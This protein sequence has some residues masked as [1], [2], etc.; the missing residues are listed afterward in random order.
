M[1][2]FRRCSVVEALSPPIGCAAALAGLLLLGCGPA[3]QPVD[4]PWSAQAAAI[5][6]FFSDDKPDCDEI[7]PMGNVEG[8]SKLSEKQKKDG[9]KATLDSA[10]SWLRHETAQRGANAVRVLSHSPSDDGGA[11]LITGEAFFCRRG[12]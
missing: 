7:L 8:V 4:P 9:M 11:Y 6:V 2:G 3:V 1:L 10:L 5:K 12:P